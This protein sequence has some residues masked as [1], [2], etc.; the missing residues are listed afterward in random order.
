M[1]RRKILIPLD[2]SSFSLL[3]VPELEKFVQAQDAELVL[4]HVLEYPVDGGTLSNAYEA[5]MMAF[6]Q[7]TA[8][9]TSSASQRRYRAWGETEENLREDVRRALYRQGRGLMQAGYKVTARVRFGDPATEILRLISEEDIDLVAMTTHARE[10]I[11]RLLF[12]SVAED[13][14]HHVN[15]PVLLL[16]PA[17]ST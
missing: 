13:I 12:G 2:Q 4:L 9:V 6:N 15:I 3:I 7:P 10:G 17:T 8:Y 11:N 1:T 16:R 5:D 14:L